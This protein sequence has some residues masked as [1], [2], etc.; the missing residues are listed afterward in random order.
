MTRE[1]EKTTT[2]YNMKQ[3]Y[4][5]PTI[6]VFRVESDGIICSSDVHPHICN[7]DCKIWHICSDRER[8]N[9][10]FDKKYKY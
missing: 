10:C 9:F 2:Q 6:T 3:E 8:G 7:D 4:I 1:D 5:K